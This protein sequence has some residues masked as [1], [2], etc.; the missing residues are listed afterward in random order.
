PRLRQSSEGVA[1]SGARDDECGGRLGPRPGGAVRY[2]S[3]VPLVAH[4]HVT[5]A[6]QLEAAIQLDVVHA[7]DAE[8]RVDAIRGECLDNVA[9]N[10][11]GGRA[12]A[13]EMLAPDT[14][15]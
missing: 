3:C 1:D 9:S 10:C 5:Q 15:Q 7:W 14:A 2:K 11:P 4:Q 6:C 12:H 13:L 8:H